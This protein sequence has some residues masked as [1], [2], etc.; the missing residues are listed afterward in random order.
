MVFVIKLTFKGQW[1]VNFVD[2]G[3]LEDFLWSGLFKFISWLSSTACSNYL[4]IKLTL[5]PLHTS[6]SYIS[7]FVFG[8]SEFVKGQVLCSADGLK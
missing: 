3:S 1:I 2:K 6:L 7:L 5:P 4:R 8:C